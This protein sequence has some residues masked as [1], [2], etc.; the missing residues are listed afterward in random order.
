MRVSVCLS[1]S[2]SQKAH[3]QTSLN[4][5]YM[6]LVTVAGSLSDHNAIR[7]VLPVLCMT[8]YLHIMGQY[9]DVKSAM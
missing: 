2:I 7:Y 3:V 1:G 6:L 9:A 4:F 5:L 8:S